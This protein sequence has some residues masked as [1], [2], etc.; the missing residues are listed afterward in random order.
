MEFLTH[1]PKFEFFLIIIFKFYC[2][3]TFVMGNFFEIV[4]KIFRKNLSFQIE[5]KIK[6]K[7]YL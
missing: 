7:D 2:R 3:K 4:V 6:N 1:G 5:Y